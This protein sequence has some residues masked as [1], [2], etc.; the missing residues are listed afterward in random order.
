MIIQKASGSGR[1]ILDRNND[2]YVSLSPSGFALGEDTGAKSEIPFR[3]LP[4]FAGPEP[5]NDLATGSNGGHT[6][7]ANAPLGMYFDG[8]NV[9][10]RVRLGGHSTA[11][12][13]YS[14][15]LDTDGI[16]NA[17]TDANGNVIPYVTPSKVKN[18]GFEYEIVFAS[19]FDVAVYYHRG[20]GDDN[21]PVLYSSNVIWRASANG[22]YTQYS[23]K[24]VAGT[25]AGGNADYFYDFYVPLSAFTNAQYNAPGI[26]A[27]TTLFR[28]SG[29]TITSAQT[30]LEGTI[31]DVGGVDDKKYGNDKIKIWKDVIPNFPQTTLNQLKD[32][33]FGCAK[34]SAPIITGAPKAYDT[35]VSGISN[36]PNGTTIHL[37]KGGTLSNGV[38]T[39]ATLLATTTVSGGVW[40]ATFT[41]ALVEND[42][43]RAKATY[44]A[45]CESAYSSAVNTIAGVCATPAPAAPVSISGNKGAQGTYTAP[46]GYTG[47]ITFTVYRVM[48]NGAY[49][50][51][52]SD[53][54]ASGGTVTS[55]T[56]SSTT[57]SYS[58]S[59]GGG[60]GQALHDASFVVTAKLGTGC[61]SPY[62]APACIGNKTIAS[63][64]PSFTYTTSSSTS[65]TSI[66]NTDT[67]VNI[68]VSATIPA[69]QTFTQ[70]TFK[71]VK[72]T[73][74]SSANYG[75]TQ[76]ASSTINNPASGTPVTSTFSLTAAQIANFSAG[77]ILLVEAVGLYSN[78]NTGACVAEATATI[79]AT[80]GAV[81][82]TPA[83]TGTY[84]TA[85]SI[86]TVTGTSTEIQGTTIT[87]YKTGQTA[88][89][90]NA[91]VLA[92]GAWSASITAGTL[93]P[94]S[95]FYATATAANKLVSNTSNPVTVNALTSN[96]GA[97]VTGPIYESA[98]TV[99]GQRPSGKLIKI[100]V[101]G[102][103]VLD[104]ATGFAPVAVTYPTDTTWS[105]TNA[106]LS[107]ELATGTSVTITVLDASATACGGESAPTAAVVVLCTPPSTAY[108]ISPP[109]SRSIC[110]GSAVSISLSGSEDGIIYQLYNNTTSAYTGSSKLG[111]GSALELTS[112]IL[113]GGTTPNV[114]ELVVKAY[115]VGGTCSVIT[116]TG[117][118]T[119]TVGQSIAT[120]VI[121]LGT[122]TVCGSGTTTVAVSN[123]VY[124]YTYQLYR[125]DSPTT[126]T[127]LVA[128][129]LADSAPVEFFVNV[130][131]S[132]YYKV[133]AI[134]G[135]CESAF[136]N[137]ENAT[138]STCT[139]SYQVEP[140][141]R[142]GDYFLTEVIATPVY[143]GGMTYTF[144]GTGL[145]PGTAV[146]SKT[147][148]I[149]V[150]DLNTLT[151]GSRTATILATNTATGEV[152]SV[153]VT[154]SVSPDN[155]PSAAAH[156][157]DP[158]V[159]PVTLTAF[160]ATASKGYVQLKWST[161]SELNNDRFEIERTLDLQTYTKIGE[162]AG[163]GT[164][165]TLKHYTF[166]DHNPALG[167]AYYRLKQVD[168][169]GKQEYSKLVSALVTLPQS[170]ATVTVAP[171]PVH[172]KATISLQ[173]LS[174]GEVTLELVSLQNQRYYSEKIRLEKGTNQLTRNWQLLPSGVYLL[175]VIGSGVNQTLKIV[176][177][178]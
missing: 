49:S 149:Y 34:P 91:V 84:C 144:S 92:G 13:G 116:L 131:T 95:S 39:G 146:N 11:S 94:G 112:D 8:E 21:D 69:A 82:A 138:V 78:T 60:H 130:T 127:T 171:N 30:G 143:P 43:L 64:T 26:N 1:A 33:E 32:G 88:A 101:D 111:N 132:T 76:L 176:M 35:S 12:K 102:S 73:G 158:E 139:V 141:Y 162:V 71:L 161:S 3:M 167:K 79:T 175:R 10:F 128:S 52:V 62:S 68:N 29:S 66:K 178:H 118:T 61:E 51:A 19:N 89:I 110:S 124:G 25:T 177:A 113:T 65:P 165:N 17:R 70:L 106:A 90:G 150:S 57:G 5:L 119:V 81:T 20:S 97:S 147:G 157:L 58:Y 74:T 77:D 105:I 98:T 153:P 27:A 135:A 152:I 109:S 80:N 103:P 166:T 174:G 50:S 134:A 85:S 108:T 121:T 114:Y 37:Y 9:M 156:P 104:P 168:T 155:N 72:R 83:I 133:K 24:S 169:D 16:F 59:I 6:D 123:A 140:A 4:Q 137:L 145:L 53:V 56:V 120:P 117:A 154:Y 54:Y 36:E 122:S 126:A 22:G 41:T 40:T 46:S 170:A 125:G 160:T 163:A 55:Q 15:V 44:T 42:V 18:L 7:L 23:Q 151:S 99:S 45:G 159:L 93:T 100:Y 14:F 164:C 107:R 2:G 31:S 63:P 96:T 115:K 86:T 75:Y 129:I 142:K 148:K 67:W 48:S 28:V 136:S 172:G 38:L 173:H 47:P 87:I